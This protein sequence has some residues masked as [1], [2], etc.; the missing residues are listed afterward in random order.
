MQL[1]L[2]GGTGYVGRAI[3]RQ[4]ALQKG[5]VKVRMLAGSA[6]QVCE[7]MGWPRL[8]AWLSLFPGRLPAVPPELFAADSPAAEPAVLVHFGVKQIDT[9]GTGFYDT[10]VAGTAALLAAT[11]SWV[12]AVLYGS[13][14]SVLGAGAQREVCE[15]LEWAP[16][17]RLADSRAEA[18]RLCLDWGRQ[19][20][21]SAFALRPRFILGE[22]DQYVIPALIKLAQRGMRVGSGRQ[23][24]SIIE[25]NDYARIVLGLAEHCLNP[26]SSGFRLPQQRPLNIGYQAPV[27][28]NTLM[29]TARQGIKGRHRSG[30]WLPWWNS[31]WMESVHRWL[32]KVPVS[33]ME[34]VLTQLALVGFDHY[35]DTSTVRDLLRNTEVES[36]LNRSEKDAL[37]QAMQDWL[38]R[39]AKHEILSEGK[40]RK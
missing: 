13:T 26:C 21:A 12:T 20:G 2:T 3:L 28:F 35:G 31:S 11:P 40:L 38:D 37:Q 25:V 16:A 30:V 22:E 9:D 23:R 29:H 32:L 17:S 5:R 27:S 4:V 14:L 1:I 24:F 7:G 15:S 34:K 19:R 6:A 18:E 39:N 36:V 8:P 10:N 33:A